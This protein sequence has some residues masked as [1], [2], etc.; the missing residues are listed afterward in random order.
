MQLFI[1]SLGLPAYTAAKHGV[2]PAYPANLPDTLERFTA[3]AAVSS[4]KKALP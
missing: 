2:L 1:F 4:V 3:N